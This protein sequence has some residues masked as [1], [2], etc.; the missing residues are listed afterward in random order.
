MENSVFFSEILDRFSVCI[1]TPLIC[2]NGQFK[3]A[4]LL[5][6]DLLLQ[7]NVIIYYSGDFDPEGLL[8][9][10][11]LVSRY[12]SQ[13]RLWHYTIED[14]QKSLSEVVLSENRLNKLRNL[15]L[16]EFAELKDL[17]LKTKKAGYQEKF[18]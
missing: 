17:M 12:P 13:V 18:N 8:M 5:L 9:A 10:Q 1:T 7:N 16:Q 3:L 2:T 14:Y 6:L 4:A 15:D 11:R